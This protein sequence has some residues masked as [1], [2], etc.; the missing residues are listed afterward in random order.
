MERDSKR[1]QRVDCIKI[2]MRLAF[3]IRNAKVIFQD[4]SQD[5]K[6]LLVIADY[7][8][9]HLHSTQLLRKFPV[10]RPKIMKPHRYLKSRGNLLRFC[11]IRFMHD[12]KI[13]S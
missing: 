13:Y 12:F 3:G 1:S 10:R 6:R 7:S 5:V 8:L 4:R 2:S 11:Q 9:F